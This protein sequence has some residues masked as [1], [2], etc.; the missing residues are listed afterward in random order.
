MYKKTLLFIILALLAVAIQGTAQSVSVPEF[1]T[2]VMPK[3]NSVNIRKAPSAQ[4]TK[5]VGQQ[6]GGQS[7]EVTFVK[8]GEAKK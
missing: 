8:L 7:W 2:F 3:N 4:S 6:T 1:V 5:L